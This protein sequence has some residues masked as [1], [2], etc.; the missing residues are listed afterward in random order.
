MGAIKAVKA[1]KI[2]KAFKVFKSFKV[3][4]LSGEMGRAAIPAPWFTGQGT[5]EPFALM[6]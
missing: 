6:S 1:F 3:K 4:F 2:F 5:P